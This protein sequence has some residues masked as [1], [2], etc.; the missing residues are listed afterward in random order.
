MEHYD[1]CV[2][3]GG[4]AGYAAA[5][6]ALDLNKRTI[7]I[8][9][10]SIGGTGIYNGALSSKTLWEISQRVANTNKVI[11]KKKGK[12]FSPT[13]SEIQQS[14]NE[15]LLERKHLLTCHMQM[16]RHEGND[17]FRYKRGH[18]RFTTAHTIRIDHED[19]TDLISAEQFIIATGSRPRMLPGSEVDE[20][21]IIT[22]DG[23]SELTDIPKSLVIVGAGVIGCEFATIFSNLG[24]KEVHLIDRADRILPFEDHDISS[25]ITRSFKKKGIIV[26]GRSHLETLS[27]ENGSVHFSI[28]EGDL[29]PVGYEVEKALIS[30]G[31]IPNLDNLDIM[32]AG[33]FIDES[34][35]KLKVDRHYTNLPHI[36]V[37]GDANGKHMLVNMGEQEGR[38]AIE[39]YWGLE[40]APMEYENV[41]SIMFLDPQVAGVGLNELG[42][43]QRGIPHRVARLDYA[44]IARAIAMRNTDGFIKLIV[45]DDKDM[46]MLGIRVAGEH[47]SS[48]IQAVAL[49]IRCQIG[50]K[51]LAEMVHPHPSIIEGV[52]ECARMLL[53][54]SMFKS[55]YFGD[56]MRCYSWK[57]GANGS[58]LA[59]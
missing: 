18:A 25:H 29:D 58:E 34:T 37:V 39:E 50:L 57:P 47:A 16:L 54:T 55:N 24:C 51:E 59:A 20:R 30:I 53:N 13:W 12:E 1:V 6:R 36:H 26:H 46:K 10:K 19:S 40:P 32:N 31:R 38:H 42:C 4:P 27:Q 56:K 48:A 15:A 35:N 3:G 5:M 9:K 45:S 28:R 21:T 23:I 2:I 33:L 11:R 22:S 7:L 43:Q 17:M 41:S 44:C 8:E 14:L 52:Q 49:M